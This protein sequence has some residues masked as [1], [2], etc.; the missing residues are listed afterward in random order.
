MAA[1]SISPINMTHEFV[2]KLKLIYFFL[3][4]CNCLMNVIFL[5]GPEVVP[6]AMEYLALYLKIIQAV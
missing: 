6:W 3:P 2:E 4:I 1:I 5:K